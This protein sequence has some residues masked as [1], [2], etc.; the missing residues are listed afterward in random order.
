M[1]HTQPINNLQIVG[2]EIERVICFKYLGVHIDDKLNFN[3]QINELVK[4]DCTQSKFIE[5]IIEQI[6]F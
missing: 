4:K 3:N 6:T 2:T 1:N 5:K